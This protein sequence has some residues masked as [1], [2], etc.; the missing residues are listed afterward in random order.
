MTKKELKYIKQNTK[1]ISLI[2]NL[3]EYICKK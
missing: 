3:I 2:I 1:I